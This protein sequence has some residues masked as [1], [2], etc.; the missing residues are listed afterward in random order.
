MGDSTRSTLKH[1][2][3]RTAYAV[4]L[5]VFLLGIGSAI[6]STNSDEQ[7]QTRTPPPFSQTAETTAI[8]S[9][10]AGDESLELSSR[11][12][13]N[14]NVYVEGVDWTLKT[15]SGEVIY[16]SLATTTDIKVQPGSYEVI[17]A[18]GTVK[19]DE[20]VN[21]PAQT[22]LSVNFVLNAG[23][24]RI[25]PRLNGLRGEQIESA[26]KIFALNG[27]QNGK[28]IT[29]SHQPGQLI[30]L[31]A[32]SYRIETQFADSNVVAVTDVDVKP[33]IMRS[34]DVD[35][36]A[37]LAHFSVLHAAENIEWRVMPD[38]GDE[39][40]LSNPSDPMAVLKPGHY[41]AEA[42]IGDHILKQSFVVEDGQVMDVVL[43]N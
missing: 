12:S 33:G 38:Q 7:N 39:L 6:A 3:A 31:A 34:V 36:H 5:V 30:K 17:A 9:V 43:A 18:Y 40:A 22:K 16:H 14:G 20:A 21:V 42:K 15:Q 2:Q 37:G 25:L 4:S 27:P 23:A 13:Q 28:L 1:H 10:N 11:F 32:G 24:L 41:T 26:A 35:H 19:I 29:T 8:T